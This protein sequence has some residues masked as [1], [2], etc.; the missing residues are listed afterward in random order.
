MPFGLGPAEMLIVGVIAVLLF[1]QRLPEVGR[2]IGKSLM[3]FKKGLN[4]IKSE[5]NVATMDTPSRPT[6]RYTADDYDEPTAPK[7]VPPAQ[8]S[9]EVAA[10]VA[11]EDTTAQV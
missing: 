2:S 8:E 7:F 1:G 5:M 10:P 11:Q 6:K 9:S 4:D 3:E